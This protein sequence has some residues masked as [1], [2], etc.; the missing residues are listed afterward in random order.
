MKISDFPTNVLQI[1]STLQMRY[2]CSWR[3]ANKSALE[4]IKVCSMIWIAAIG[5]SSQVHATLWIVMQLGDE[6]YSHALI[7]P[8]SLVQTDMIVCKSN[9]CC[10]RCT[11]QWVG[12]RISSMDIFQNQHMSGVT[13][14]STL[15]VKICY[16]C[17]S[18]P[19]T[20]PVKYLD[21]KSPRVHTCVHITNMAS[22]TY[23]E[24]K[25]INN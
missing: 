6:R 25:L 23:G 21:H 12:W 18:N 3:H 9:F 11:R 20:K 8:F 13:L 10:R 5:K 19:T 16:C 15:S 2:K 4:S 22:P 17:G 24:R 7:K 14:S 1:E